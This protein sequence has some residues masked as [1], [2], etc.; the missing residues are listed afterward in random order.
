[1]K[2]ECLVEKIKN[3]ISIAEKITGKNLTLNVLS[4]VLLIANGKTLKIRATNLDL[5]VEIEIPAK[6]EKEGILAIKGSVLNNFLSGIQNEK[7][8]LLEEV[9]ENI[10]V[11]TKNNKTV[12][13]CYPYNDFPTIPTITTGVSF[14]IE[15]KIFNQGV[16]YVFYSSATTEIKPEIASVYIYQNNNE[17]IFVSTDSFRLAEKRIKTKTI[18]DFNGVIIPFKNI[19]EIVK[20]TENTDG[21]LLIKTTKNQIS[22]SFDG[23]YITS[24]LIDGVFPDYQQIIPKEQKTEAV[25]LKQDIVNAFKLSNTFLDKFNQVSFLVSPKTKQLKIKTKNQDVGETDTNIEA[26]ISGEEVEVNFNYRY[27]FDCFQSITQDSLVLQFNGNS[28][29]LI[30]KNVSDSSFL[31]LV[32]PMNR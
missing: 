4:C 5:G 15:S 28:K 3:A 27:I 32:M 31:Y 9:N 25:V 13:K 22:I 21:L 6:I 20:I 16:K 23:V 10:V 30:I 17:L 26:A 24:R 8:V 29:P 1:M 19:T 14:E 12:I 2:V 7:N 18:S 11:T